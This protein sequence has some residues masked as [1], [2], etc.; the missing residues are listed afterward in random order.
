[1]TINIGHRLWL[2]GAV[3][4]AVGVVGVVSATS[5]QAA[6]GCR[7]AYTV[8]SQWQGRF[9]ASVGITNLGDA[10]SSWRSTWAWGVHR[11]LDALHVDH[12]QPATDQPRLH[13]PVTGGI[14][15]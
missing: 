7:V 13:Q 3:A 5:A 1:M 4:L 6:T 9:G 15:R 14:E 12:H 2:I 10:I 11:T 8:T